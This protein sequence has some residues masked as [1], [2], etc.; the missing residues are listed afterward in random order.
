MFNDIL[1]L[2][3]PKFK[4]AILGLLALNVLIYAMVDTLTSAADALAW[5]VLLV[6]FELEAADNRALIAE[7]TLHAI[8]NVL[9]AVIVLV[10]ISYI[11]ADEW[12]DV[13]NGILWFALIALLELEIRWPKKVTK[14]KQGFWAATIAMFIALIGMVAVWLWRSEW[15]DAYDA[16]LWIAAFAV[17]EVD[18]FRF[19]QLKRN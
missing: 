16:A 15:L 2:N 6:M 4:L 5:L 18:I 7:N 19:L 10:F 8:R 3:Y 13:I 14:H 11:H 17:I 12:L 9:I 1:S